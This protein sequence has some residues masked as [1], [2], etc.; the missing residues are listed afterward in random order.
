VF[1]EDVA[2]PI[3]KQEGAMNRTKYLLLEIHYDNPEKDENSSFG[4]GVQ[5]FYTENP[6]Y[7]H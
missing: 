4:T 3:G 7:V 2:Y 6:R 1:P 5:I